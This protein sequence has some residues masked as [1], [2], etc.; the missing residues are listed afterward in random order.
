MNSNTQAAGQKTID[1]ALRELLDLMA[2]SQQG[3]QAR[4]LAVFLASPHQRAW[5]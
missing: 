5:R 4:S 1:P 3:R 2:W